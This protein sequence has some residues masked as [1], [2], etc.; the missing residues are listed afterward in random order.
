MSKKSKRQ[1]R[2]VTQKTLVEPATA[3]AIAPKQPSFSP[4]YSHVSKDLRRVGVL[5]GSEVVILIA[6]TF[7]LH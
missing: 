3:S 1:A 7:F 5:V 2:K 4:D 6:L